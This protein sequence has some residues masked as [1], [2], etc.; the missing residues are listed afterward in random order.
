MGVPTPYG[1]A[2]R[3]EFWRRFAAFMQDS[4]GVRCCAATRDTW[5]TLGGDINCGSLFAICRTR[6]D[7]IGAQ[8]ALESVAAKTVFYYLAAHAKSIDGEL[9]GEP[10]WRS[11]VG[12]P[13]ALIELRRAASIARQDAWPECFDWLRARL[14]AFQHVLWPFLGRVPP[15]GDARAWDHD[16]FLTDVDRYNPA[17]L[18]TVRALLCT[19]TQAVPLTR[20][21]RGQQGSVALG[22]RVYGQTCYPVVLSTAATLIFDFRALTRL[23]PFDGDVLRLELLRRLDLLPYLAL[24]GVV[25]NGRPSVPVR[26]LARP[27]AADDLARGLEWVRATAGAH[28]RPRA[29]C[30]VCR[31]RR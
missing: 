2:L 3:L 17:A 18:D 6:I 14:E 8:F 29:R 26:I 4:G 31:P 15:S 21:S 27:G 7:T 16:S 1:P 22:F 19:V 5:M 24:P 23:P 25:I 11:P 20:W 30:A 28:L 13:T 10:I 9:G 12:S